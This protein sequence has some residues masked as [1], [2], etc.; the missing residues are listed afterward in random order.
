M[1]IVFASF[2]AP[3]VKISP[4]HH[5]IIAGRREIRSRIAYQYL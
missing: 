4:I 3:V 2:V 5:L 1:L